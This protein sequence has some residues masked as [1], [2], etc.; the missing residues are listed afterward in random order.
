MCLGWG[1]LFWRFTWKLEVPFLGS[2]GLYCWGCLFRRCSWSQNKGAVENCNS[3]GIHLCTVMNGRH[4][5]QWERG[6]DWNFLIPVVDIRLM[7]AA[8]H[9]KFDV[10]S[11]K[12]YL[13]SIMGILEANKWPLFVSGSRLQLYH[14]GG[15]CLS[16]PQID[17][18]SDMELEQVIKEVTIFY[19]SS[20]KHKLRIV[21]VV[22]G[23]LKS[24]YFAKKFPTW[25]FSTFHWASTEIVLADTFLF[26]SQANIA[27]SINRCQRSFLS[28][29]L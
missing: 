1:C 20:P 2:W 5:A 14:D 25:S 15:S 13:D 28:V 19:R 6:W 17:Q 7:F 27:L 24:F 4:S 22:L 3:E 11:W 23:F 26:P 21:K 12:L 18:M 10:V 8:V 16:G 29:P 9:R